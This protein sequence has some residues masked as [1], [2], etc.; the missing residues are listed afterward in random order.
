M[1]G[2]S[3]TKTMFFQLQYW[4][5]QSEQIFSNI[6]SFLPEI[7][8]INYVL[9]GKNYI[10]NVQSS[11]WQLEK[12]LSNLSDFSVLDL[13]HFLLYLGIYQSKNILLH[14]K[15]FLNPKQRKLNYETITV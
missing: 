7:T 15:T 10:H 5:S 9:S 6:S 12:V 1:L 8:S 4:G 11:V 14:L 3:H 2:L 13:N